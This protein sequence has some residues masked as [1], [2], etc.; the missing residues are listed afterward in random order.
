M[1][2]EELAALVREKQKEEQELR[3]VEQQQKKGR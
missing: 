3:R 2:K 1:T